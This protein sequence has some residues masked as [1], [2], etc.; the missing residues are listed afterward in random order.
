MAIKTIALV[1]TGPCEQLTDLEE[2]IAQAYDGFGDYKGDTVFTELDSPRTFDPAVDT[3]PA[4][5]GWVPNYDW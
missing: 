1:A 5:P 3:V 2:D 4:N